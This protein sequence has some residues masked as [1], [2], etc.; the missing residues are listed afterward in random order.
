MTAPV[1]IRYL[2]LYG[3]GVASQTYPYIVYV[4]DARKRERMSAL[5]LPRTSS[6]SFSNFQDVHFSAE[7][8]FVGLTSSDQLVNILISSLATLLA[9]YQ[10]D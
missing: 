1:A 2:L 9:F 3:R 7:I 4:G 8:I 5:M 6:A 10:R